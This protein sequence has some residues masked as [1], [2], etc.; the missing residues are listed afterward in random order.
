MLN[1]KTKYQKWFK[2][3][4]VGIQLIHHQELVPPF[5]VGQVL[6]QAKGCE[7]NQAVSE[8]CKY[9]HCVNKSTKL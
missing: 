2:K 5:Q 3:L 9:Q 4:E 1:Q 7:D 6:N 8:T